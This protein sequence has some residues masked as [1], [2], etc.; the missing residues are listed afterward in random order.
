MCV[1]VILNGIKVQSWNQIWNIGTLLI[2]ELDF[3]GVM[4]VVQDPR[5]CSPIPPYMYD[6]LSPWDLLPEDLFQRYM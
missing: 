1:I 3:G 6:M 5:V 4:L 2:L